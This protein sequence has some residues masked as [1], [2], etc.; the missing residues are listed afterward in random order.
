MGKVKNGGMRHGDV[1]LISSDLP[2]KSVRTG[3]RV[4][5]RVLAEGEVTGHKHAILEVEGFERYELEG[6]TY[7]LVTA[8]GG[9]RIDHQE[10]GVGIVPP[11][12]YEERIDREYD[13]SANA[14]RRVAD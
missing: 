14:I 5:S 6:K 12:V 3:K 8:E 1:Y 2:R 7:L 11:G 9:V 10:H 13:Y 4:T